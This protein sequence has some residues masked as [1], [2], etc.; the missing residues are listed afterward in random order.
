MGDSGEKDPEV[1][2]AIQASFPEQVQEIWIRDI[3]ND[4]ERNANRL[5]GM[6]VIT[7]ATVRPGESELD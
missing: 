4:R 1:Y 7:A 3:V 5:A 6:H 2:R